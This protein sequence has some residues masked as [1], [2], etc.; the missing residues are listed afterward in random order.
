MVSRKP[1]NQ[2]DI[3]KHNTGLILSLIR[4]R[5]ESRASLAKKTGMSPAS[6][7]RITEALMKKGLIKEMEKFTGGL[8]RRAV[9]LNLE[10]N[11]VAVLGININA[12]YTE[13][14]IVNFIGTMLGSLKIEDTLPQNGV[15]IWIRSV[16]QA[17]R[18]LARDLK[19]PW[20]RIKAA[21]VS[22]MGI[23]NRDTGMAIFAPSLKMWNYPLAEKLKRKLSIPIILE[24]DQKAGLLGETILNP[25]LAEDHTILFSVGA[26]VGSAIM[27]NGHF[28]RGSGYTA[29]EIGHT[30]V[31]PEGELCNCGRR[32]CLQTLIAEHYILKRSSK[33]VKNISNINHLFEYYRSGAPWAI[34]IYN[35]LVL[36]LSMAVENLA[37]LYDPKTIILGGRLFDACPEIVDAIRRHFSESAYLPVR[38]RMNLITAHPS[39]QSYMLG[40]ALIGLRHFEGNIVDSISK[41]ED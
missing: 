17:S 18:K 16:V 8:G 39:G 41:G 5:N 30:I 7:T 3:K 29:G 11:A 19:V 23:V 38:D 33:Y 21:G 20:N 28:I 4:A 35:D 24:H 9:F 25:T 26:G 14:C 36:Y 1:H 12:D 34:D 6:V 32:G 40:A 31:I 15:E 27:E 13:I 10:E 2:T 37:C 22:F